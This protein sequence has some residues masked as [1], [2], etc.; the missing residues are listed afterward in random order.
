MTWTPGLYTAQQIPESAYHRDDVGSEFPTLSR[1]TAAELV[2]ESPADAWDHHPQLGGIQK[3][4]VT[5]EMEFASLVH[6]L[7]L[8]SGPE[9]VVLP[10]RF[11]DYKKD[12]A[13]AIR[14]KA[15]EEGKI[16]ILDAEHLEAL[17]L[18][19][20]I[21]RAA[22]PYLGSIQ[23]GQPEITV[24]WTDDAALLCDGCMRCEAEPF[25]EG[26]ECPVC[27]GKLLGVR[28]RSRMDLWAPNHIAGPMIIDLKI[29]ENVGETFERSMSPHGLDMQA[30]SYT[31]AMETVYP[32]LAGRIRFMFLLCRNDGRHVVPV[33]PGRTKIELGG[34]RWDRAV[35]LWAECLSKGLAAEHWPGPPA[36]VAEASNWELTRELEYELA[37][38]D[39]DDA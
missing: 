26:D 18:S 34:H 35:K 37:E 24:L 28:C 31:R 27:H 8:G 30:Y 38:G 21:L 6:S 36:R 22:E 14:D 3:R 20:K 25:A 2:N 9:F 16:P 11:R 17:Q 7:I 4:K 1:S 13:Q 29:V 23:D 10:E 15:R 19:V 5:R 12:E 33:Y 39:G 32:D